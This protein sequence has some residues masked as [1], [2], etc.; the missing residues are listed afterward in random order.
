MAERVFGTAVGNNKVG[1]M[2]KIEIEII[3]KRKVGEYE[4]EG[5]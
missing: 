3:E 5:N 4:E 1:N 2:K